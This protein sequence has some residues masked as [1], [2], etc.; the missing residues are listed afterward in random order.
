MA[1]AQA[2][3]TAVAVEAKPLLEGRRIL[4]VDADENVRALAHEIL[5]RYQC[6]VETAHDGA[7]ARLMVRNLGPDQQYDVIISDLR[8][9]DM[10]AYDLLLKLRELIHYVP[11]VLMS[12]FG[13]DKD[14]TLV[15]C[16]R[17]GVKLVIY[18]PFIVEQLLTAIENTVE[19]RQQMMAQTGTSE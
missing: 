6:S 9:P 4:V 3:P 16:R 14:H 13:W 8:L 15:K 11:L 5:D 7:E 18:K 1:P 17:E 12:G 10:S 2:Y 19:E